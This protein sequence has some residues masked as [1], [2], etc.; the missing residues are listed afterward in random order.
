MANE[1][2]LRRIGLVLLVLAVAACAQSPTPRDPNAPSN[3]LPNGI[4]RSHPGESS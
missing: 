2:L 4:M 1:K 3:L